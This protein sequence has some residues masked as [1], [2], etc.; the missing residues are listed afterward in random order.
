MILTHVLPSD[1]KKSPICTAL[2]QSEFKIEVK[3][4]LFIL[5][6]LLIRDGLHGLSWEE[7]Q[8]TNKN[9]VL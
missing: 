5:K 4:R 1:Y 7:N 2:S 6:L 9:T 3:N 8:I